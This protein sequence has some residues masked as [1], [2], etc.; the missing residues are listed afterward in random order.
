M[1]IKTLIVH[2]KGS[3]ITLPGAEYV[4]VRQPDGEQVFEVTDQAHIERLLA[5]KEGFAEYTPGE[6][7]PAQEAADKPAKDAKPPADVVGLLGSSV[8]P[9][10]F[11]IGGQTLQL[12]N[13]VAMAHTNSGLSVSDWNALSADER[14]ERL[15]AELDRLQAEID[16][17]EAAK[18]QPPAGA[19]PDFAVMS[20]A[21]LLAYAGEHLPDA[22]V[23]PRTPLTT[24]RKLVHKLATAKAA[25]TAAGA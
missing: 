22:T 21:A 13:I 4:P 23:N 11:E 6:V 16:A 24:L 9:S 1:K 12:D 17:K 7:V 25:A 19:L 2:P 3:V 20:G 10:T 14:H 5:I 15:D 18:N 8:H